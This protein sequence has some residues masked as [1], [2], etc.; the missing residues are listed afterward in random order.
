MPSLRLFQVF[1]AFF[2][3]PD[4]N[5]VIAIL[6]DGFHLSYLASVDLNNGARDDL[7][8]FVPEMCHPDLVSEET[9]S[10]ALSIWWCCFLQCKMRV[11]LVLE[12]RKC[13]PD[14]CQPVTLR[15]REGIVIEDLCL[16]QVL[17]TDLMQPWNRDLLLLLLLLGSGWGY[18]E[19]PGRHSNEHDGFQK[20]GTTM[21][22]KSFIDHLRQ[23]I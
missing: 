17:I 19:G 13:V 22:V 12:G 9:S 14:V 6:F 23:H 16:T 11:D 21:S 15:L 10:L 4:L 7:T 20:Q 1:K 5:W 18:C 2:T 8:P 3:T